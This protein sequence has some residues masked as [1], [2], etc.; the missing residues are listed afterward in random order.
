MAK[1]K[2]RFYH[3]RST[4]V[5]AVITVIVMLFS[6]TANMATSIKISRGDSSEAALN[7]LVDNTEYLKKD[8]FGRLAQ[9]AKGLLGTK[10]LED[11]YLLAGTQIAAEDYAG[12]LVSVE[13]CL[14]LYGGGDDALHLDLLLKQ[15][16]LQVLLGQEEEALLSLDEVVRLSPDLAD[17]Y[18]IRAQIYAGQEQMEPLAASLL[19]YLE[20]KPEDNEIRAILA[21]AMFTSGDYKSATRQYRAIL[22][23]NSSGETSAE[24][25]YL[26][27]LASLQAADYKNAESALTEAIRKNDSFEGIYYYRGV[28]RMAQGNY[29]AA[30]K[31]FTSSIDNGSLRQLSYYSR[32]VSVLMTEG[33]DYEAAIA[34][35]KAA[36]NYSGKDSDTGV[37]KEAKAFLG[38]LE[39]AEALAAE[40]AA[41]LAE[42]KLTEITP[43]EP[44]GPDV[45]TLSKVGRNGGDADE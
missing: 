19:S 43:E 32:G 18:L 16:C 11:Y 6:V 12:A 37:I 25:E 20:L 21:Q 35:L 1:H 13:H 27:G 30:V 9:L 44:G 29:T 8:R 39:A 38:E 22:E 45:Y 14:S 4:R 26:Y 23:S 15:G 7:Y 31:D 5:I 42:Q 28:C 40:E 17:A 24:T 36:A 33:Y 34:D 2:K 3:R 41:R 10:A